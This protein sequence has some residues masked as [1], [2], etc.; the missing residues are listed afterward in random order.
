MS[1][2][3]NNAWWQLHER[4]ERMQRRARTRRRRDPALEQGIDQPSAGGHSAF[5]RGR[6]QRT[7]GVPSVMSYLTG[8]L[9]GAA[10]IISTITL[11][12]SVR[13]QAR[14]F[15]ELFPRKSA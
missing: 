10:F 1:D 12:V 6:Q 14:R 15:L 5:P 11:V 7:R 13:P 2:T 8:A 9:F 4:C 3:K